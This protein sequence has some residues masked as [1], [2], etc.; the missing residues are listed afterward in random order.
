[1]QEPQ[2]NPCEQNSS[3]QIE[4]VQLFSLLQTYKK[5][6]TSYRKVDIRTPKTI[7]NYLWIIIPFM[8]YFDC[9]P[10]WGKLHNERNTSLNLWKFNLRLATIRIVLVMC[11]TTNLHKRKINEKKL[12][13]YQKRKCWQGEKEKNPMI[14]TYS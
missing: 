3:H 5:I 14:S 10:S 7:I 13:I 9:N 8:L 11:C 1:M 12:K 6:K 4:A 2:I